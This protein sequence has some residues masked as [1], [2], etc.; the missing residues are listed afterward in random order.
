MTQQFG[1][2]PTRILSSRKAPLTTHGRTTDS[3]TEIDRE[4]RIEK[5]RAL[6]TDNSQAPPIHPANTHVISTM[7]INIRLLHVSLLALTSSISNAFVGLPSI[8]SHN[9]YHVHVAFSVSRNSRTRTPRNSELQMSSTPA[10]PGQVVVVG[11]ANQDLTAYTATVPKTGET[12]FGES[13]E[14]SFGGKGANQ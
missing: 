13:F 10:K 7:N 12:V 1:E 4:S 3:R 8:S 14:T 6:C 11:S 5:L 2:S 9:G